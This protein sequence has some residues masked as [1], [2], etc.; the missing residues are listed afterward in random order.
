VNG[1]F[2]CK[3]FISLLGIAS[4]GLSIDRLALGNIWTDEKVP[5]CESEIAKPTP[6]LPSHPSRVMKSNEMEFCSQFALDEVVSCGT[7]ILTHTQTCLVT[8]GL[9][10]FNFV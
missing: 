2:I 8:Y 1:A 10:V 3:I 5:T 4:S 6:T 9:H 7:L